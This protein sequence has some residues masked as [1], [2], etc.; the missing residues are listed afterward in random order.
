[1]A[2]WKWLE[3]MS[4]GKFQPHLITPKR[5]NCPNEL[6]SGEH[7]LADINADGYID[8][9]ACEEWTDYA[10][11]KLDSLGWHDSRIQAILGKD[12]GR[13]M[14]LTIFDLHTH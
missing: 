8:M 7:L 5:K 4:D 13:C 12:L 9:I 14:L 11:E 1:V 6:K 10:S 3:N 2:R